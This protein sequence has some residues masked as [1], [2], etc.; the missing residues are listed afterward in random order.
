M[1]EGTMLSKPELQY[2]REIEAIR[3]GGK[4]WVKRTVSDGKVKGQKEETKKSSQER[5][6]EEIKEEEIEENEE[7]KREEEHGAVVYD[8]VNHSEKEL[9]EKEPKVAPWIGAKKKENQRLSKIL[10]LRKTEDKDSK[11]ENSEGREGKGGMGIN[12]ECVRKERI[13]AKYLNELPEEL[14]SRVFLFLR[15]GQLC[16]AALVA[17]VRI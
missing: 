15:P 7:N 9:T 1:S 11:E 14:L 12:I 13:K 8:E 3:L 5:P 10:E 4:V 17:K 2:L 16:R 6:K